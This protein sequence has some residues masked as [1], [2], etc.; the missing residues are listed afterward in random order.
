MKKRFKIIITFLI[1]ILLH[2]LFISQLNVYTLSPQIC[3]FFFDV[4]P[5]EFCRTDGIDTPLSRIGYHFIYAETDKDGNLVLFL[6][7]K[8]VRRWKSSYFPLQVLQKYYGNTRDIGID[9]SEPTDELLKLFY[10]QA[11]QCGFY[12]SDDFTKI[13]AS[14]EDNMFYFAVLPNACIAMQF[15][16]GTPSDDIQL[17]YTEVDANGN[18]T[19]TI[20]W[21][22]GE[23]PS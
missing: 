5:E 11:E 2:V 21:L 17:I 9:L 1:S 13:I 14:P 20:K 8:Q 15:F 7:D 3:K 18:V 22:E 6:T 12:I 19:K 23:V 4:T 10:D 16:D